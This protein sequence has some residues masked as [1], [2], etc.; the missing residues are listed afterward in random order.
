M[1]A[2]VL[3]YGG[4]VVAYL[5]LVGLPVDEYVRAFLRWGVGELYVVALALEYIGDSLLTDVAI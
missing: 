2:Q 3:S 4:W 5:D 1:F